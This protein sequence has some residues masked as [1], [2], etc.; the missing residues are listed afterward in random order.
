MKKSLPFI[1]IMLSAL[2]AC[3]QDTLQSKF[4]ITTTPTQYAL[5]DF[6]ITI[7]KVKKNRTYGITLGFRANNQSQR[8]QNNGFGF[9]T[10]YHNQNMLNPFYNAATIGINTKYYFG[11]RDILFFDFQ[12]F[13]RYWWFNNK[14]AEYENLEGY[15]FKGTRSERQNVFGAKL[16]MGWTFI[17]S[18]EKRTHSVFEIYYG[19][20]GRYKTYQYETING[21]IN[22]TYYNS[23]NESGSTM[24]MTFHLGFRL[25]LEFGK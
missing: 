23:K 5:S 1:L 6:P 25:G 21:N 12:G 10:D 16:L 2:L 3:A 8:V 9:Y 18:P 19:L 17:L 7:E 22:G 14:Y 11:R 13:Y 4:R 15:S 24:V 20:G